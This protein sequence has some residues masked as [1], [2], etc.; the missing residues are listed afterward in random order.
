M[1]TRPSLLFSRMPARWRVRTALTCNRAAEKIPY[2][3]QATRTQTAV[4]RCESVDDLCEIDTWNPIR[5]GHGEQ[6]REHLRD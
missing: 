2:H 6:R 5:K 1:S 3:T 4:L